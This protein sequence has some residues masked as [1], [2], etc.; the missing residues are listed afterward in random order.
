MT[1]HFEHVLSLRVT[2]NT[3]EILITWTVSP[4]Q[5]GMITSYGYEFTLIM[6][7]DGLLIIVYSLV[8]FREIICK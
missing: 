4:S 8:A 2:K 3:R 6:D 7:V 1:G 5:F